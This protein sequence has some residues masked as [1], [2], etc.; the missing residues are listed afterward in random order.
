ML[1]RAYDFGW[2]DYIAGDELSYFDGQTDA[3]ILKSIKRK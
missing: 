1:Q 2:L 3:Q